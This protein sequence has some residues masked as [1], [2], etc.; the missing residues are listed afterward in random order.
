MAFLISFM[1]L[2]ISAG[3]AAALKS[4]ATTGSMGLVRR[5]FQRQG[6][7]AAEAAKAGFFYDPEDADLIDGNFGKTRLLLYEREWRELIAVAVDPRLAPE[8][9][10]PSEERVREL[11]DIGQQRL[12]AHMANGG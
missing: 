12:A 1:G 11:V 2:I 8:A 3:G 4:V 10:I 5:R 9:V 6:E 7:E